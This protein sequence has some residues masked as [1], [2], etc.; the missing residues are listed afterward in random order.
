MNEIIKLILSLSLSG[1][2]LALLVFAMKPFIKHKISKSLQYY[3]WIVVLLRLIIPFSF[4]G[5]II[6]QLMYS[7]KTPEVNN[8]Q[9]YIQQVDG[10]SGSILSSLIFP[11]AQGHV[12]NGVYH[13]DTDHS[14]YF[15]D[16][17]IE[18]IFYVWLFGVIFAL[19]INIIGYA[20]FSKQL[21]QRNILASDEENELLATLT[22]GRTKIKLV[23]NRFITTPILIGLTKPQIV[24]PDYKFTEQQLTNILLHELAHLRRFDLSIKWLTMIVTSIHW[25]NPLMYIIKKEI[26][27]ACEMSCDEAVIKNLNQQ[28]KQHYGDTL[29]AV[30][31]EKKDVVR[32]LQVTMCDDKKNLKE[33]LL[34]IMAYK[35]KPKLVLFISLLLL[36]LVICSAIVLGASV[37]KINDEITESKQEDRYELITPEHWSVEILPFSSMSFEENG[38]VVGGID[39]TPYYPDQPLSQLRSNHTEV[40]ESHPLEGYFT[41]VIMEKI[42]QTPP[43]ASGDTTVTE[44]LHF[45]FIIEDKNTAYNLFFNAQDVDEQTALSIANSFTLHSSNDTQ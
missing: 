15:T 27:R 5:S 7:Y 40:I 25:F 8:S 36:L 24:I 18:S 3:I 42:K 9:G 4:E 6:N 32:A 17:V 34:A 29:I 16:L 35:K 12:A 13:N 43:A 33:R 23:R 10:S 22:K 45:Y 44:T 39:V 21:K 19:T 14:R 30:V 37:E 11:N 20:R 38:N 41:E 1:S 26:N 2:I 31:A 28:Q